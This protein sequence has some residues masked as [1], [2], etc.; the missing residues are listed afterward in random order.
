MTVI[1]LPVEHHIAQPLL[2]K[3]YVW[4]DGTW[5]EPC[6]LS[7]M[8]HMSDDYAT[9]IVLDGEEYDDAAMRHVKA[10]CAYWAS[11]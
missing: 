6:E 4:A 7:Q 2:E 9:V 3:I 1:E 5:C 8:S 10:E 11:L